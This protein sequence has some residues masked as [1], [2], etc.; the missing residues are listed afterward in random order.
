MADTGSQDQ[1]LSVAKGFGAWT[2]SYPWD[3]DFAAARNASIEAATGDW[4]FQ[5]DCDEV[6][7][8]GPGFDPEV[9]GDGWIRRLSDDNAEL[10]PRE[11]PGKVGCVSG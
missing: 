2:L 8:P 10:C 5:M 4:I 11:Q 7:A 9:G 3:E 1:S 6:I